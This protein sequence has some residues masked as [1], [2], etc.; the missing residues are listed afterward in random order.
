MTLTELNERLDIL[1]QS[2][3][4]TEKAAEVAASAFIHLQST[5]KKNEIDQAEMLFTHLPMALSRIGKEEKVEAPHPDLL[6][7]VKNSPYSA[8][9]GRE[10]DYVQTL[11]TGRLPQEELDY[12]L[13]HYAALLQLNEG[14][15]E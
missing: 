13:M 11:W 2:A 3:V 4:I 15:N 6:T 5:L 14:G 9:A 1:L 12:L 7:E 8:Q 10:I